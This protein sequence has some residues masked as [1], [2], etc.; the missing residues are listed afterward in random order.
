MELFARAFQLR[1]LVN[2]RQFQEADKLSKQLIQKYE[3][4]AQAKEIDE[5]EQKFHLSDA[6]IANSIIF[7]GNVAAIEQARG[8]QNWWQRRWLT[9]MLGQT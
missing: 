2:E 1:A 7:W 3:L 9:W 8:D 6:T 5:F 4:K